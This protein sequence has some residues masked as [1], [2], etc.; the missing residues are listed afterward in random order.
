MQRFRAKPFVDASEFL[1][2]FGLIAHSSELKGFHSDA[3]KHITGLLDKL[4]EQ[5]DILD[6]QMTKL[7]AQRLK[8][9]V[10]IEDI[11]PAQ[12]KTYLDET[13]SRMKDEIESKYLVYL[14]PNSASLYDS[15]CPIFGDD[16][17][18]AFPMAVEDIS[19]AGK[20]IG[21][22]RYTAGVFHLMRALENAVQTLSK[23]LNISNIDRE[24]GKLLSDIHK[25]IEKLPKGNLRD[26]WS[27]AHSLLYHVK[28]AW[29]NSTMH[30]KQTYTEEEAAEI[31][32]ATKSFM[33][34]LSALI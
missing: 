16:V 13:A 7:S 10:T 4:I 14:S 25:E 6:L 21:L 9:Q 23:K 18:A 15:S 28:Q 19:E 2:Q 26:D 22:G 30:P 20:C 12:C 33:R 5:L 1:G 31:L 11:T 32:S 8:K 24:W 29:R 27:E 34:H 17:E 3:V